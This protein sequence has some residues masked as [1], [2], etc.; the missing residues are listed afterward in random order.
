MFR[1][2]RAAIARLAEADAADALTRAGVRLGPA[3]RHSLRTEGSLRHQGRRHRLGRRALSRPHSRKRRDD[4][5]KAARGGRGAAWQDHRRRAR[6]QRQSGT[7]AGRAIPGTSDEGSSGSSAGSASATA[8]GLCG[9]LDRHRDARLDHLAEPSLRD[10]RPA[11]HIRPRVARRR[12]GAV[13][14][15]RQGRA[16]LPLRRGHGAGAR[17]HQR[18]RPRRPLLDRGAVR[19]DAEASIRGARIGYLPEAFGEGATEVDHAAL[20]AARRLGAEVVETSLE[21]LPYGSLMNT[22]YAEAAAAFEE[23]T[24]DEPRRHAG[25][26]GRRRLAQHVPQG[27]L[28]LRRRSCPARSAALSGHARARQAV[29]RRRLPDWSVHDR[30]DAGGEQLHRPSLPASARGIPRTRRA[31]PRHARRRAS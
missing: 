30:A 14:V 17:R 23:L 25:A 10:D 20:E 28:P 18:R 9:F 8:A 26:A 29:R 13:L 15:A 5:E 3:A 22:L 24:L 7:A 2:C 4:R 12:H 16:D 21:D 31:R 11:A 6:L 1:G 19:F 27:A